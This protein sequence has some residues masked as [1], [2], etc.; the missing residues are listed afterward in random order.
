MHEPLPRNFR[1]HDAPTGAL[2]LVWACALVVIVAVACVGAASIAGEFSLESG[3]PAAL[4]TVAS[5]AYAAA[6]ST[7]YLVSG[8][9]QP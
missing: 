6:P 3:R 9:P 8:M 7:G 2:G 5:T 4:N 1:I